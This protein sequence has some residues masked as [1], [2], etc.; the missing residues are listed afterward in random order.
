MIALRDAAGEAS[1]WVLYLPSDPSQALHH[2]LT[3]GQ[4]HQAMVKRLN[5]PEYQN[6][7]IQLIALED[8]QDFVQLLQTRL[9]DPEPD[10]QMDGTTGQGTCSYGWSSSK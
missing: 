9:K 8:R 5:A 3:L 10:L 1:G 4:M 7:F 6:Y 2:F